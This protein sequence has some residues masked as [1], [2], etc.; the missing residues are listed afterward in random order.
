MAKPR[1]KSDLPTIVD[2]FTGETRVL[3]SLPSDPRLVA[4]MAPYRGEVL[5]ES[6][7]REF[8]DF[9]E[10]IKIKDQDGF[11]ACNGHAAATAAEMA[12]YVQGMDHVPL[13]AW[14]VYAILC[15]GRDVGSNI[16]DAYK[17]TS[18][19]GIAPESSVKYGIIN[20]RKLTED[21]HEAA[22]RFRVEMGE[23]YQSWRQIV[24]AVML[25]EA[26]NLSVCVGR[27]YNNL[28][29]DGV[30][31][32]DRGP[33]NHAIAV[34]LG[35]KKTKRWGWVIKNPGSWS[36]QWGVDGFGWVSE[37]MIEAGSFF[38]CYSVKAVVDDPSDPENPPLAR[39]LANL[40]RR[41]TW[42]PPETLA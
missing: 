17:L 5:P 21:A 4:A 42:T 27:N 36:T 18:D 6:E 19:K 3:G 15:N 41:T 28:D 30:M 34:G 9:P 20:P 2:P 23:T 22:P 39:M 16:L 8:D 14:Y 25:R 11:G 7:L 37:A 33:G 31:G 10:H 26:M 32:V 1:K 40:P 24:S 13:S 29:E 38:E 12:R 35:L